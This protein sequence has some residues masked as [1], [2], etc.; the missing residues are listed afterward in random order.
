[1]P[2]RGRRSCAVKLIA[3]EVHKL[4]GGVEQGLGDISSQLVVAT[5]KW[6]L[7]H[8]NAEDIEYAKFLGT[9]PG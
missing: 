1:M 2:E 5:R 8:I 9:F 4:W 6:I 3:A 7:E